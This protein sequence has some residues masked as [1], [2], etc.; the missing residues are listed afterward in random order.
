[1]PSSGVIPA[2]GHS[3]F[4]KRSVRGRVST[5]LVGIKQVPSI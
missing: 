2:A 5:R 4:A 3:I 1:M